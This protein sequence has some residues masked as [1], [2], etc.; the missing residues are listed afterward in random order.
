MSSPDLAGAPGAFQ[1]VKL[2]TRVAVEFAR[3]AG[4]LQTREGVVA[5]DAH[6][7]LLTG[8][9]GERWPVPRQRFLATYEPCAPTQA[10]QPGWYSKRPVTVWAL[11]TDAATQIPLASGRGRLQAQPGDYLVQYAPGD[12][13]VVGASIFEKTYRR[14]APRP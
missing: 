14:L 3:Q 1:A 10:A 13:A 8:V 5:Y 2:G 7:A 9:E 11:R 6:D 12:V 4:Q